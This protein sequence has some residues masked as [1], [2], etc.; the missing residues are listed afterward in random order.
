MTRGG[1]SMRSSHFVF[2]VLL[3]T[4]TTGCSLFSRSSPQES[5]PPVATV[6]EPRLAAEAPLARLLPAADLHMRV[7]VQDEGK[8]PH[9]VE[10]EWVREGPALVATYSGNPY[11]RWEINARA[12]RR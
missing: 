3:L 12:P 6:E 7:R 10:E 9:E 5:P 2:L 11:V 1:P 4:L 8:A